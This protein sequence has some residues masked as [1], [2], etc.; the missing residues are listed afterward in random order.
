MSSTSLVGSLNL[1]HTS[2]SRTVIKFFSKFQLNVPSVSFQVPVWYTFLSNLVR[3]IQ[4]ENLLLLEGQ[5]MLLIQD[6]QVPWFVDWCH[7]FGQ[8]RLRTKATHKGSRRQWLESLKLD[9]LNANLA[10]ESHFSLLKNRY[11][12]QSGC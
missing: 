10:M 12:L 11:T 7:R 5:L 4:Q 8:W 9:C 2:L 1:A 6:D 3:Q